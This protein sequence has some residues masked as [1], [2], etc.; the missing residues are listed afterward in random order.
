MSVKKSL[1]IG[2]F[3]AALTLIVFVL[4]QITN[5][6]EYDS[7]NNIL[8]IILAINIAMV[9]ANMM[10]SS[11]KDKR[12]DSNMIVPILMTVLL[13]LVVLYILFTRI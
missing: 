10:N 3:I 9:T 11:K 7:N 2:Q 4:L 8:Y 6:I 1:Q 13:T 12:A 5:T